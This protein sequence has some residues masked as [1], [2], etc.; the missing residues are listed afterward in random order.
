MGPQVGEHV[1]GARAWRKSTAMGTQPLTLYTLHASAHAGVGAGRPLTGH[2][3]PQA[4]APSTHTCTHTHKPSHGGHAVV[5]VHLPRQ[6]LVVWVVAVRGQG[7]VGDHGAL[8]HTTAS[9]SG[10]ATLSGSATHSL[11]PD[12]DGA[13]RPNTPSTPRDSPPPT[14]TH[15]TP[16]APPSGTGRR[17]QTQTRPHLARR[18][19]C[20]PAPP[21]GTAVWPVAR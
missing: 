11:C 2:R 13:A 3:L 14:Y 15:S 18:G 17:P 12:G 7:R 20:S 16:H 8:Q 6:C 19:T 5:V 10:G 1:A 21:R 9:R 4:R